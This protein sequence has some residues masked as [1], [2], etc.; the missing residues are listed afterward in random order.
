MST[1]GRP[2]LILWAKTNSLP[3]HFSDNSESRLREREKVGE[4]NKFHLES[5]AA[6]RRRQ[7][8]WQIKGLHVWKNGEA[9]E[10]AHV[11]ISGVRRPRI[12]SLPESERE[13]I[14]CVY[15]PAAFFQFQRGGITDLIKKVALVRCSAGRFL[16]IHNSSPFFALLSL[17]P[18]HTH[19]LQRRSMR[20]R[21]C[22]IFKSFRLKN[23]LSL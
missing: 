11:N 19:S 18:T 2:I 7:Y 8:C 5:A 12:I 23:Y 15:E 1:V 9:C 6:R 10:C 20:T 17:P 13:A 14:L 4:R 22:L 16:C 3:S 21:R